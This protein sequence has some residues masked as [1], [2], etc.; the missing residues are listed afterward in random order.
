MK[1]KTEYKS[2]W[3][4]VIF[5]TLQF[6]IIV[7]G[8]PL[9]VGFL[10]SS[11]LWA[12]LSFFLSVP[13]GLFL[14]VTTYPF[15]L[16]LMTLNKKRN[17]GI[18]QLEKNH[19]IFQ[20]GEEKEKILDLNQEYKATIASN[21]SATHIN[22]SSEN[23]KADYSI[24]IRGWNRK[25]TLEVFPAEYFI[26]D[27]VI[28]PEMGMFG[29]ELNIRTKEVMDFVNNLLL[30]LW[31]TRQKNKLFLIYQKFPWDSL[32]TPKFDYIKTFEEKNITWEEQQ[33]LKEIEKKIFSTPIPYLALTPDYLIA[34]KMKTF[35]KD[36][37][38]Y[39][40]KEKNNPVQKY[41]VIPLGKV[42]VKVLTPINVNDPSFYYL[43]IQCYDYNKKPVKLR[44]DW[45][46]P[47]DE[48]YY[49]SKFFV[50]FINSR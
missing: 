40:F 48:N 18:I 50:Q 38:D 24:F 11:S 39:Y 4:I 5:P 23:T 35:L 29:F 42:K 22:I 13:L 34:Y 30:T 41:F 43:E 8:I 9:A 46:G 20:I 27:R 10:T 26:E 3:Y 31:L 45:I 32:P 49:E 33:F 47:T 21:R 6:V 12:G 16:K 28:S 14:A 19:L 37:S 44:F 1:I 15:Y 2:G 7:L 36:F 25:K 17:F